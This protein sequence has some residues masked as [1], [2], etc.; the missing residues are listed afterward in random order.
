MGYDTTFSD[1]F[2]VNF[3]LAHPCNKCYTDSILYRIFNLIFKSHQRFSCS[4]RP[5]FPSCIISREMDA[6]YGPAAS[7]GPQE[8]GQIRNAKW[9]LHLDNWIDSATETWYNVD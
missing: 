1:I 6:L 2:V 5:L 7:Y 4:L 9:P 8:T 3:T